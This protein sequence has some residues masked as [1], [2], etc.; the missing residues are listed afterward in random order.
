VTTTEPSTATAPT[1]EGRRV[2]AVIPARGGSKGVPG[3]NLAPVAGVPLV[4]RAVRACL[5]ARLVTDVA[6]STDDPAIAAAARAA[7]AEAVLRPAAIA[8]DTATSESAVLHA[9]DAREALTGTAVDVVLLVQC[10]SPFL[11]AA[12]VDGV[13]AAVVENGADTAVTVAPFHGFVWRDGEGAGGNGAGDG[14]PAGGHGVNH[15]KSFRPRRQDRPQDFLE[16]GAAYAMDAAGFRAHRH[17][18]FGR[19]DLVR[20][21][22]ARVL[23]I[24]DPHDL[25]RA[26]ALA[27]LLDQADQAGRGPLS[28][29]EAPTDHVRKTPLMSTITSTNPRLRAF[30]SRLVGPGQ[31]VYVTGEIGINHN[32]DLDNAIA[33]IDAAVEAGCDA[34]KFQKRT[35]EICTPRDQ[36]DI[37]RDT[38]WGRMT[39]ID[40]RHRVEFGEEEYRAIDEHCKERGIHWFA[41]PWDT[42][43]VAFLEK[44]DLPAHK[45]ASASL[46]DDELL[47][48]LRATGRAVILSTGMSTPKQIRHAVEVLGSENIVLCHATSTYPAKAEEL[49]LRVIN[50]LQQEY[51]NVPIGYSGHETGLQTTLAAVAL[52]AVFVERHITL[53]RAMWG[54]DQAASVEPQGLVRLV[55][56]IRTIEA[57]LGDGVKKVYDSELGPMK[58]LRRVTGVVAEAETQL[59]AAV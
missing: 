15:D 58:K 32:G 47:R 48:A 46:T 27:P 2:L 21:D 37:E 16:T 42:E 26:R 51:P 54:S 14:E 35:P 25:A 5:A 12:D 23:E 31:P 36:W 30:G 39:Y 19:T 17:R 43:A 20:T 33:L 1:G 34:V 10:T 7:G 40:Y 52:G 53:D 11:T 56:D 9:L 18:F 24:D 57:S 6:V 4:A 28:H 8:G 13:A 3:K 41:S 55:R 59:P 45:V 29:R 49:N 38:P 50:T 22:P 44:F